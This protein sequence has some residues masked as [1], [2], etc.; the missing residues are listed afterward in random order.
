MSVRSLGTAA[1][2][3][4]TMQTDLDTIGNDIA[5]SETD[6]FA[7][8]TAQFSDL[9]TEQ[10]QPAGGAVG[11]T[12]AST[13]PSA[14]GAG[15]EVSAIETNFSAGAVTQTGIN[16]NV[17]IEG[18][19]FLVVTQNDQTYYTLDG[20]LQVDSNGNLATNS[21]GLVEGW[22]P[23]Q[24]TTSPPTPLSVVVGSTGPPAETQNVVL[25]GNLPS[26]AT[27]P[28]TITTTIYDS[29]GNQVPVTLTLT[30]TAADT[31][32][33][34]GTVTG[35][36]QPLWTAPQTLVFGSDGQLSTLNGTAVGTGQTALA[37]DN[38][39]SNYTWTGATE[40][41]VDF[42]AVGSEGAVTQFADDQTIEVTSQDGNAAGTLESYSIGS[43]G[44]I[45]G[46]YS[47][48]DSQSLGTI[49]LAQFA[50]PDGLDDIGQT[51]FTPTVASGKAQLGEPGTNGLGTLQ[52]GAVEGSNVDLA[53][54]LT[55]LIEAQT[56]YQANTK[57]VDTS[58]TVLQSLVEMS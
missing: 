23:G 28:V 39:P 35:A 12:L 38:E 14:I 52:G 46:T 41:S 56:A 31:W 17:A 40:P 44:V 58:S 18:N 29:L 42:P 48:G 37:I 10:L 21:G 43:D 7:S 6:G 5:N 32:S 57:V 25:G 15:D 3:I 27:A 13:N 34:Q 30:P 11:Q 49:A 54:E 51:Y 8:Q 55:D 4:D 45:T 20:D 33:M 1:S 47:N 19:G 2:G 53:T 26:N 50:N 22:A 36:A 16:S 9:L 24:P